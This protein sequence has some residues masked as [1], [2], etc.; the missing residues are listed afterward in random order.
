MQLA[1]LVYIKLLKEY[2]KFDEVQNAAQ[3]HL[4]GIE[5]YQSEYNLETVLGVRLAL[6]QSHAS[7]RHWND[8]AATLEVALDHRN[9]ILGPY[10]ATSQVLGIT[11]AGYRIRDSPDNLETSKEKIGNILKENF[12][13]RDA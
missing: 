4:G 3:D 6:A 13:M 10:E 5:R 9:R 7:Q 1:K 8:A 11:I 12:K 2:G